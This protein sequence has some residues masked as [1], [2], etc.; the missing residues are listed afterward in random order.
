MIRWWTIK[1]AQRAPHLPE[2][3]GNDT[4]KLKTWLKG[5]Q[6]P[7]DLPFLLILL[8]LLIFGLIILYSA[9]YAV[10]LYRRGD[11]YAYI[12]PQLLYAALGLAAM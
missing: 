10:G 1:G 8:S 11:A 9:S 12:R 2:G 6:A 4:E 3:E 7:A 5:R